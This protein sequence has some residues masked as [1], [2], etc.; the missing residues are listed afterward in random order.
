[1]RLVALTHREVH[2]KLGI[3]LR[4]L[5]HARELFIRPGAR[6][7]VERDTALMPRG[8]SFYDA[9]TF[10]RF[11]DARSSGTGS[12]FP[13]ANAG[14]LSRRAVCGRDGHGAVHFDERLEKGGGR[15]C[16]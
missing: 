11:D 4:E 5:V 3:E 2:A 1:M 16:E 14:L 7:H 12:F 10:F 9:P 8:A 15:Y 13:F 6:A